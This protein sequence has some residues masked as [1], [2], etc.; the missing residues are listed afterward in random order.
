MR[1]LLYGSMLVLLT[2]TLLPITADAFSRRS[3]SSEVMPTQQTTT[4]KKTTSGTQDVS[5]QAVPEPPALLL[6]TIGVGI[7]AAYAM[8]KRRRKQA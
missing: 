6:M 4:Y 2:L 8:A 7:F 1:Q 3:G 5:A